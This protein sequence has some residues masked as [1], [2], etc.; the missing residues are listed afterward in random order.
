MVLCDAAGTHL[1]SSAKDFSG[2]LVLAI[3]EDCKKPM[4]S[5]PFRN[6]ACFSMGLNSAIGYC[7]QPPNRKEADHVSTDLPPTGPGAKG[8][9]PAKR[10]HDIGAPAGEL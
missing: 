5:V 8:D 1:A 6:N 10:A 4:S 7:P 9:P 3:D 2:R